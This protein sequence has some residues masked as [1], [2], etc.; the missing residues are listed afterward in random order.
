[1][2][3]RVAKAAAVGCCG[4]ALL[5]AAAVVFVMIVPGGRLLLPVSHKAQFEHAGLVDFPGALRARGNELVDPAG[6]TVRLRGLMPP[7]PAHMDARKLFNRDFYVGLHDTGAN[8][9]RVAVHP[10]RWVRDGDY[11]WRHLDPIVAWAGEMGMYAIVDWHYIGNIVSGAG[12]EMPDVAREPRELTLEFWQATAAYFRD[13]PNVIFEIWNEP[14][15]GISAEDWQ[16]SATEIVQTIRAQGAR[17]LVIVGGVE[18]SR[19]LSWV[20]TNPLPDDNTA[21]AAHIYPAHPASGWDGWFGNT[22]TEYPVIV[23]EWGFMDENR[24]GGPAYLGGSAAS[25]GTPFLAYLDRHDIGWVA[26][27]YDDQWLPPMFA[28]G[29]RE[30]TVYG[31]FVLAALKSG[32]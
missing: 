1:M 20:P 29:W 5:A 14:A 16:R 12:E 6:R 25:Y 15:G 7:D 17:Q 2:H 30:A 9:V 23:T 32:R 11:L 31:A 19:D 18:Y 3:R 13:T 24:A 22:S 28:A 10:E 8:V 4:L 21:Y 27:W 26:C